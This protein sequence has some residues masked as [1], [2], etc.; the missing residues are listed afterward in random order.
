MAIFA[1]DGTLLHANA[2]AAAVLNNAASSQAYGASALTEEA[3]AAG[4]ASGTIGDATLALKRI[5]SGETT[6]VL[7]TWSNRASA[8]GSE[9][10]LAHHS[11][12]IS[13]A[14]ENQFQSPSKNRRRL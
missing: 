5:G 6:S 4:Y 10:I 3:F 12:L 1:A 9:P 7:A 2:A 13:A 14:T 11:A 8:P